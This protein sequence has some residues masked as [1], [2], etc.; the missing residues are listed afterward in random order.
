MAWGS[1]QCITS[2]V[3][4]RDRAKVDTDFNICRLSLGVVWQHSQDDRPPEALSE[5]GLQDLGPQQAGDS[6]IMD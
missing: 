1:A 6:E 4:I 2:L 5:Q 3:R